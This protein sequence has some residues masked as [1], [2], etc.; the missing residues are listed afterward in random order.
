MPEPLSLSRNIGSN[1][2]DNF[3]RPSTDPL[4]SR[5]LPPSCDCTIFHEILSS[6]RILSR[7]LS[8]NVKRSP[9]RST[10]VPSVS[11]LSTVRYL[12]TACNDT[13]R[14]QQ[15]SYPLPS[16]HRLNER[17]R[18]NLSKRSPTNV[19]FDDQFLFCVPGK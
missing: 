8:R 11:I 7:I 5:P 2:G 18:T 10:P 15:E 4:T 13:R 17:E 3:P 16:L 19:P 14:K 12:S 6:N 1:T 9:P